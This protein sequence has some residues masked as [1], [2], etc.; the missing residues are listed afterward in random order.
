MSIVKMG[1]VERRIWWK[2][3]DTRALLEESVI[4]LSNSRLIE[5]YS[6]TF[7]IA[8]LTVKIVEKPVRTRLSC[9]ESL[10]SLKLPCSSKT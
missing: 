8:I 2:G 4:S 5:T 7:E 1:Q 3:T 9:A 6:E 10:L